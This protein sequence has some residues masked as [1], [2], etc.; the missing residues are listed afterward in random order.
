MTG[1]DPEQGI[2]LFQTGRTVQ[3]CSEAWG[4]PVSTLQSDA[5]AARNVIALDMTPEEAKQRAFTNLELAAVKAR[6]EANGSR[7]Y[8]EIARVMGEYFGLLTQ[9]VDVRL[10]VSSVFARMA[11][12]A[13]PEPPALTTTGAA[14]PELPAALETESADPFGEPALVEAGE[15]SER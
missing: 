14:V 10:D 8:V 12:E 5:A 3:Q 4:I 7:T 9:N 11:S 6:T 13:E 15:R 1:G 2:P